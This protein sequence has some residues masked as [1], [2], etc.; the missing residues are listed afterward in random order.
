MQVSADLLESGG[1]VQLWSA[2]EP[3]LYILVLKLYNNEGQLLESESCQVAPS[4]AV[5]PTRAAMLLPV[6][7]HCNFL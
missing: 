2:E 3:N 4:I 6:L 7:H 5:L 1:K